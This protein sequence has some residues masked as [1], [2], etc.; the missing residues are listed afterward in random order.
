LLSLIGSIA[1]AWS[2]GNTG[3]SSLLAPLLLSVVWALVLPIASK[4][5]VKLRFMRDLG[6]RTPP[7]QTVDTTGQ[8]LDPD[9]RDMLTS[10]AKLELPSMPSV[11]PEYDRTTMHG[12]VAP[13]VEP[14]AAGLV[15]MLPPAEPRITA[16]EAPP[17]NRGPMVIRVDVPSLSPSG[18]SIPARADSS[19]AKD[20]QFSA[21]A[22]M[23]MGS[24]ERDEEPDSSRGHVSSVM[25]TAAAMQPSVLPRPE[26]P[27][28]SV[29][30]ARVAE[31]TVPPQTPTP[32][33]MLPSSEVP[34]ISVGVLSTPPL[35][36]EQPTPLAEA[37]TPAP[38]LIA[39]SPP[40][41]VVEP[42]PVAVAPPSV[43]PA[44]PSIAEPFPVAPSV[45]PPV[46]VVTTPSDV[47]HADEGSGVRHVLLRNEPGVLRE[48][49]APVLMNRCS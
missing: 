40:V 34:D 1:S 15:G 3:L 11:I 18:A 30:P 21:M 13:P 17:S 45:N 20:G 26:A 43:A 29:I 25:P 32:V 31:P 4:L 42:P 23:A 2:S 7:Q 46:A 27:V 28:P 48:V 39:M 38:I 22:R 35:R 33:S 36:I 10:E 41:P 37:P 19:A 5:W 24:V 9:G 44:A 14:Y 6:P 12:S 8:R 47:A 49:C 16:S